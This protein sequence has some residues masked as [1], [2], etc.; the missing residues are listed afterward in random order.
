MNVKKCFAYVFALFGISVSFAFIFPV[1]SFA[2]YEEDETVIEEEQEEQEE[3]VPFLTLESPNSDNEELV[4]SINAL[5]EKIDSLIYS[6]DVP[7][8]YEISTSPMSKDEFL[9]MVNSMP[10]EDFVNAVNDL[11]SDFDYT[12]YMLQ[13]SFFAYNS[14]TIGSF[15][16]KDVRYI[17]INSDMSILGYGYIYD[18]RDFG[19][20]DDFQLMLFA[21]DD[22]SPA[23]IEY[24]YINTIK[25]TSDIDEDLRDTI[26]DLGM[27]LEFIQD[28]VYLLKNAVGTVG[29]ILLFSVLY[30]LLTSI[31]HKFMGRK[32]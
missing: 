32:D 5:V 8:E 1:C 2:D 21:S 6:V 13:Y 19:F 30:P 3:Y 27:R 26:Y 15:G 31:T 4:N 7:V 17:A 9:M 14:Y 18:F 12:A 20:A 22:I 10:F 29:F 24:E 16:D 28:D 25:A 11:L 23:L